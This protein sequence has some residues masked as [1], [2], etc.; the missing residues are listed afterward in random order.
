MVAFCET[1]QSLSSNINEGKNSL[2][3]NYILPP[4]SGETLSTQRNKGEN[5][6]Y[7]YSSVTNL[8]VVF[9]KS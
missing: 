5:A 1:Q 8:A 7:T 6:Q 4:T 2:K 9:R 3:I